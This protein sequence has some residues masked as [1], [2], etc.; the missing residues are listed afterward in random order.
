MDECN[1]PRFA[2]RI[3]PMLGSAVG[4]TL[5]AGC[6]SFERAPLDLTEHRASFENRLEAAESISGFV[7]RLA[8]DGMSAPER[9]DLSDGLSPAEGEVLALFYNPDLRLARLNAGIALARYESA[10]L[11]QDPEFG[12]DAA[13]LLSPTGPLEFGL[14][15]GLTLP[16]SGRLGIEE[17]HAHAKYKA[18]LLRIVDE[19]WELR[20]SIRSAWASWA[21]ASEHL[22]LANEAVGLVEQV[23][24]ITD[25]LEEAEE[26]SRVEARL[27]RAELVELRA[28]TALAELHETQARVNLLRLLGLPPGA[29]VELL[30]AHPSVAVPKVDAPIARVIQANT[31]L[32][33]LRE[34]YNVREERLRL[35]VRKQYPDISING[36]YGSE[37]S[38]SRFLFGI[39]LPLPILNAN[40]AGIAEAKAQRDVARTVAEISLERLAGDFALA[41]ASHESARIQF[42]TLSGELVPMLDMQAVEVERLAELGEVDTLLLLETVTRRFEAKRQVLDLNLAILDAAVEMARLLGPDTPNLPTPIEPSL[43]EDSR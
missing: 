32:A 6:Q 38:D 20:A 42:Q 11:W 31:S 26:L 2:R 43:A 37:D 35:Q 10:G 12:F 8:S 13:E 23:A 18:E 21:T 14:T 7:E 28:A 1:H 17:D 33:V 24:G 30:P 40:R 34:E 3:L 15:L 41:H 19:E 4:A 25:R 22:R 36:G 27:V 29:P 9:F 16:I 39:S 5:L